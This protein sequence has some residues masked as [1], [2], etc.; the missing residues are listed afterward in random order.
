VQLSIHTEEWPAARPF[1]ITGHVWNSFEAIVVELSR[2]GAVG[3]GEALGVFY[4]NE[5][6]ET[7]T[8]EIEAIADRLVAGV[9]RVALQELLP[10]GGARNAVDCALWDLEAKLSGRTIWELTGVRPKTLETVYTISIEATPDAMAAHAAS[11]P[12]LPLLKVKLDGHQ[13]LE[14]IRAI[15]QARPDARIVV[16]AN[17][18]WTFEQLE[19]MAPAFAELGVRMIEQPLARGSDEALETYRSPVPL[20]A[21]ESCLHLGELEQAA[22]RY[23]MINIKLDKTGGLT[24]A[25]ELA[26]SARVRGLGLM[27]GSM[28][29]SSLAMAPTFVVGCLCDLADLDGPLLMKRDRLPGLRFSNG[30]VEPPGRNVW[31]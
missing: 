11:V 18:G 29:G 20:C 19:T 5:T 15:R 21:D 14:R 7:M 31:G 23:Q 10:A 12:S 17:Q 6:P 25:L 9:D 22:R 28:C 1:R 4:A 30:T 26:R 24:H 27:V 3:R 2:A 13:P 16:D 8:A